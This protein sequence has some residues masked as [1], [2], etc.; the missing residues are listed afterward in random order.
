MLSSIEKTIEEYLQL[1][2]RSVGKYGN[3]VTDGQLKLYN[4]LNPIDL[5]TL[6]IFYREASLE[7]ETENIK[8]DGATF[9]HMETGR[10]MMRQGRYNGPMKSITKN[11]VGRG[12]APQGP[13]TYSIHI[14]T[15]KDHVNKH[16]LEIE[17]C[18]DSIIISIRKDNYL[19]M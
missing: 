14:G 11:Q 12:A 5:E 8:Y 15:T 13:E 6:E 9:I 2:I 17:V 1:D 10:Y 7:G 18:T 4:C 19:L 16:G 3:K